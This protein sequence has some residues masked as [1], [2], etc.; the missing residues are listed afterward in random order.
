V[1]CAGRNEAAIRATYTGSVQN[2]IDS[3][4][5]LS[6]AG[7]DP[8]RY[9]SPAVALHWLLAAGLVAT[10][11]VG[12]Q[13]ADMPVSPQRIRWI[14]YHKWC[15]I[16][17]LALSALRLLWRLGHRPPP[18]PAMPRLQHLAAQWTHRLLYLCFFA[19]PLAGW[20]YSCAAGFHVV[21]LGLFRL[22]D[23][24][25]KDKALADVL[26][27]VHFTLA[28]SLAVLVGLHV[29]AA[30][31]HHFLDKDGMLWRMSL[32]GPRAARR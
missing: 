17:T 18:M 5:G 3:R 13:A 6:G 32:R 7:P 19:V 28:W 14:N 16:T 12:L 27:D 23:L 4:A 8:V 29:A 2:I 11:L 31:K 15:G 22:P 24:V 25:A 1:R 21:Y 9:G 30:L 20:A 26:Q 10:F